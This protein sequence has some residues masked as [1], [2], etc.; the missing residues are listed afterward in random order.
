MEELITKLGIDWKL[1][2]AQIINFVVLL[3]I[4]KKFLYTPLVKF[5]NDRRE[6]ITKGLE[7]AKRGEEEFEKIQEL[8]EVELA[9][10]QKQADST[11]QM[12]KEI[13]N[14]KQQE[15]LKQAEEKTKKIIL[16]AK[17]RVGLEKEKMLKQ[18]RKDIAHLVIAATEKI[19]Q[20]KMDDPQKNKI[21]N[22]VFNELKREI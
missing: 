7:M 10:I 1:L 17:N 3:F 6:K 20:Q 19:L 18:A 21:I 12:A 14:K 9:K 4:L 13:A 22:K 11:I 15:I 2:L 16:E 5:M 8:K